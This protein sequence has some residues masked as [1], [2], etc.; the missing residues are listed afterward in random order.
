MSCQEKSSAF[1]SEQ[2]SRLKQSILAACCPPATWGVFNWL[3]L[4]RDRAEISSNDEPCACSQIYH[5]RDW[6]PLAGKYYAG[7]YSLH[8]SVLFCSHIC[9][10]LYY[11]GAL[12]IWDTFILSKQFFIHMWLIKKLVWV[13]IYLAVIAQ[14]CLSLFCGKTC[15]MELMG[16]RPS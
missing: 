7:L 8:S 9:C 3:P 10:W 13:S 12:A 16:R 1:S 14:F 15:W 5:D 11:I 2:Q 4:W 6:K